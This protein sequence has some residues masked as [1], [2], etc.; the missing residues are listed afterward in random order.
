MVLCKAPL[1]FQIPVERAENLILAFCEKL[2]K[3]PGY[4]LGM[5]SLRV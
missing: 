4:K 5:V 3:A 1:L 2:T